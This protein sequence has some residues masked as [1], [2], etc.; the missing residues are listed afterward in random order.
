[1]VRVFAGAWA[2]SRSEWFKFVAPAKEN[3][4]DFAKKRLDAED[5]FRLENNKH[6]LPRVLAGGPC[7]H[8]RG[9]HGQSQLHVT[10]HIA[11]LASGPKTLTSDAYQGSSRDN[12]FRADLRRASIDVSNV[13]SV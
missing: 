4:Y 13:R 11:V 10:T 9:F 1:M 3:H 2:K 12:G 5:R 8:G 7:I 6:I